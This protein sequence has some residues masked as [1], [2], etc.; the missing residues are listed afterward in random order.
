MTNFEI[1]EILL[2]DDGSKVNTMKT[3]NIFT[4][5]IYIYIYIHIY[6]YIY[7]YLFAHDNVIST[8]SKI[9]FDCFTLSA[10]AH[11]KCHSPIAIYLFIYLLI[12]INYAVGVLL[13][14]DYVKIYHTKCKF[15]K[16]LMVMEELHMVHQ[17]EN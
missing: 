8:A 16:Y 17:R 14:T 2:L 1:T 5:Y 7:I 15:W 4:S 13:I 10:T 3:F 11:L 9:M 12:L 6:I